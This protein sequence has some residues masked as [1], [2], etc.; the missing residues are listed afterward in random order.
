MSCTVFT[1]Y[2]ILCTFNHTHSLIGGAGWLHQCTGIRISDQKDLGHSQEQSPGTSCKPAY[3]RPFMPMGYLEENHSV[4]WRSLLVFSNII[5]GYLSLSPSLPP[6]LPGSWL[7]WSELSKGGSGIPQER[8]EALPVYSVQRPP[9]VCP[10][11]QSTEHRWATAE[12]RGG[13]GWGSRKFGPSNKSVQ[14]CVSLQMA[15]LA[16]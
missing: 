13:L 3:C 5:G 1:D 10:W 16:T 7:S 2:M 15:E 4:A 6:S 8:Q 12:P 14:T 9:C 11:W